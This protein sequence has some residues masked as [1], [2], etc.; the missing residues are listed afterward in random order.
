VSNRQHT[1]PPIPTLEHNLFRIEL[2]EVR[3]AEMHAQSAV[4]LRRVDTLEKQLV[5]INGMDGKGGRIGWLKDEHNR[6]ATAQGERIGSLESRLSTVS[7]QQIDMR[8]RV[9]SGV[10]T[11]IALASA[12]VALARVFQ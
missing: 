5:E 2:H 9:L 3:F 4:L 7:D 10:A 8:A 6:S 12:G 1:P 11:V